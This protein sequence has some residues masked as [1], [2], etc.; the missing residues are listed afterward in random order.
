MHLRKAFTL[1]CIQF[2]YY[3]LLTFNYR[4]IATVQYL[5]TFLSDICI[6]TLVFMSIQRVSKAETL[7]ERIA[8]ILGGAT[9]A[10]FALWV[11]TLWFVV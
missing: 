3:M 5:E 7:H 9:G 11:S 2:S 6:A 4:A 1:F 8:Y 10:I